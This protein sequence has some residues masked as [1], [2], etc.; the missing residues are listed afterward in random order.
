MSDYRR[1]MP[2]PAST[3]TAGPNTSWW[4]LLLGDVHCVAQRDPAARSRFEAWTIYPGVHAM[5]AYRI[6]HALWARGWRYVPR[7]LSFVARMVTHVDIH[8]GAVIG[9]RCFIDHGAGVVIGETAVIGN[10]VTLYHGVTLG[11]TSWHPGKRHPTLGDHVVIGVGAKILGPITIGQHT[12]IAANSVVI[13]PVPEGATVVG[14]PGRVVAPR[15][16]AAPYG[17]DLN[18]HLIPDPV[19]KA[20]ACL[21]ERVAHLEQAAQAGP[22]AVAAQC[23]VGC[24][25]RCTPS[26]HFSSPPDMSSGE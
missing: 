8:P 15:A 4:S 2:E 26:A 23:H 18:H 22:A 6:A 16:R 19:G 24:D 21:L 13:D 25:D 7:W 11:G 5:A 10:D 3:D 14:I 17:F 1:V 12:R 9:A 20:L